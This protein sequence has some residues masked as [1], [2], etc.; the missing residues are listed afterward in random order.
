MAVPQISN[1]R[2]VTPL[3][4][5]N[6]FPGVCPTDFELLALDVTVA[7]HCSRS[8]A[9]AISQK[10]GEGQLPGGGCAITQPH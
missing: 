6:R 4:Y 9:K 3:R 5:R 7:N 8:I 10:K 1:V 2:S